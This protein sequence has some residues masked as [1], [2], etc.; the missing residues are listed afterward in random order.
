MFW[1]SRMIQFRREAL[2]QGSDDDATRYNRFRL[3]RPMKRVGGEKVPL[4]PSLSRLTWDEALE[5][6]ATKF[7]A[8]RCWGNAGDRT[9]LLLAG[10]HGVQVLSSAFSSSL[11]AKQYGCPRYVTT[12]EQTLAWTFGLGNFTNATVGWRYR[13]RRFRKRRSSFCFWELIRQKPSR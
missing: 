9:R 4:I 1:A 6:I 13:E 12:P 10:C 11:A 5:T 3:T 2:R 8:L 7:L